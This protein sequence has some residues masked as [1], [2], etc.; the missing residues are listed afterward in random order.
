MMDDSSFKVG[1]F[2][3]QSGVATTRGYW[4]YLFTAWR[5]GMPHYSDVLRGFADVVTHLRLDLVGL[6]EIDAGSRRTKQVDQ[7]ALIGN[8]T[9]LPHRVFF[10]TL[11]LGNSANQ[12][13]AILSRFPVLASHNHKL[14]G[15][16]EPRYLGEARIIIG[17]TEVDFFT[18][19]LSL[20]ALYRNKQIH[21]VAEII[22]ASA[23]PVIL[24]G[25]FN[26]SDHSEMEIIHQSKLCRVVSG[27]TFPSWRPRRFLDYIFFS[28]EF[29]LGKKFVHPGKF[30]DHLLL[31]AEASL[32]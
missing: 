28:G 4:Q 12:G 27:A 10:P 26:V 29:Q 17:D 22:N 7:L 32:R 6:A 15:L 19:H 1:I 14:P 25:D 3:A 31:I 18:T 9:P 2:N 5:Y 13:N 23:R 30:S 24:T 20:S 16:G 8:H 21:A 11:P